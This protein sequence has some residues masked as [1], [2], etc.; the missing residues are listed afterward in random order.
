MN[1]GMIA[2]RDMVNICLLLDYRVLDGLVCGQFLAR[3]K[4]ILENISADHASVY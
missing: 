1:R 3:V 4:E 2:A